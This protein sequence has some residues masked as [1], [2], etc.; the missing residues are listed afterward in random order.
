[1]NN[2]SDVG[3]LFA[4]SDGKQ[5]ALVVS[6]L[7]DILWIGLWTC[8]LSYIFAVERLVIIPRT[9]FIPNKCLQMSIVVN[10]KL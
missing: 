10:C 6:F 5:V 1:M 9:I 3:S 8:N 4:A 7:Y 2:D